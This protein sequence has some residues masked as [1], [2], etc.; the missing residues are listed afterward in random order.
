MLAHQAPTELV[1]THA[2]GAETGEG[3]IALH[4]NSW[5]LSID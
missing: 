3:T 5:G 2:T 4:G 1:T